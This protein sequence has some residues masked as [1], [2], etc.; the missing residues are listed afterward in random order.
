MLIDRLVAYSVDD[1]FGYQI[2]TNSPTSKSYNDID[3][4]Y[5]NQTPNIS[6]L[7]INRPKSEWGGAEEPTIINFYK[8]HNR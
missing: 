2:I 5:F 6:T 4:T 7:N 8:L 1:R 3:R